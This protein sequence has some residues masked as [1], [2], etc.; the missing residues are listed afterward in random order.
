MRIA[1]SPFDFMKKGLFSKPLSF[2]PVFYC[3]WMFL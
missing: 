3:S 1:I 2:V